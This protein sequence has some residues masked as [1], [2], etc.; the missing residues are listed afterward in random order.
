[1]DA[2]NDKDLEEYF[3]S[4]RQCEKLHREIA[5][6]EQQMRLR[7]ELLRHHENILKSYTD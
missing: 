2:Q 5:E 3:E 7:K 4:V 6:L 1:M